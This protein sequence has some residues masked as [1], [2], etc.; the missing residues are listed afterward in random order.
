MVRNL[1]DLFKDL[2]QLP[3]DVSQSTI[4][5]DTNNI[6]WILFEA[7]L[8]GL[9]RS[10]SPKMNRDQFQYHVDLRLVERCSNMMEDP[11]ALATAKPLRNLL[12][13]EM[14]K[15]PGD[16]SYSERERKRHYDMIVSLPLYLTCEWLTDLKSNDRENLI[17]TLYDQLNPR[18]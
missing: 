4:M 9:E 6:K 2:I 17:I 13:I 18:Q 12:A 3:E 11:V 10:S 1:H 14:M 5:I 7:I 15:L 16:L 8:N